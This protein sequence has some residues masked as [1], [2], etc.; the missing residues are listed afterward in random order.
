MN[1]ISAGG[2]YGLDAWGQGVDLVDA[3]LVIAAQSA[4]A[5]MSHGLDP[6]GACATVARLAPWTS[7]HGVGRSD[8]LDPRHGPLRELPPLAPTAE[9]V[10]FGL[11]TGGCTDLSHWMPPDVA[12][13]VP[14]GD[15]ESPHPAALLLAHL[16]RVGLHGALMIPAPG[17]PAGIVM[18]AAATSA[19]RLR[20]VLPLPETGLPA[21]LS[22]LAHHGLTGFLVRDRAALGL[23]WQSLLL[24]LAAHGLHLHLDVAVTAWPT[25]LP[26]VLGHGTPVRVDLPGASRAGEA[27]AAYAALDSHAGH[28]DLW[29]GFSPATAQAQGQG[30]H[31]T[32][33]IATAGATRLLWGS[34][35][36]GAGGYDLEDHLLALHDLV[37]RA[38]LRQA[39]GGANAR[40]LAFGPAEVGETAA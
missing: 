25:L 32:R 36:A 20:V 6:Q 35:G 12:E 19:D 2:R 16:D 28:S 14:E 27:R 5:L 7:R 1:V 29:I 4:P 17:T 24:R 40:W 23:H 15:A 30:S 37:P 39:I 31:L 26:Q 13:R 21:N 10:G 18:D 9:A 34:G 33:L 8:R 22:L 38:D 11:G 3:G